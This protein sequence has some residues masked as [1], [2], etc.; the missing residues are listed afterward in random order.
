ML[1]LLLLLW[2]GCLVT[3]I[4]LAIG[5]A[6]EGGAL[7]LA[8][9]LGLSRI[10]VPGVLPFLTSASFS[11][12]SQGLA[13]RDATEIGFQITMIGVV[14]LVIGAAFARAIDSRRAPVL[15]RSSAQLEHVGMRSIAI[16][17]IGYFVLL[18]LAHSVASLTAV[19][20]PIAI[21][22]ILGFWLILYRLADV[23][24]SGRTLLTLVLL[25]LLP[26]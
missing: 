19:V 7:T 17:A 2:T 14:A 22:L 15:A 23:E 5:R 16:G 13:D 18:P 3:L 24:D 21:L 8:Y 4:G 9:F 26:L 6:R 12:F 20:S 25:P 10:H 11:A 1:S